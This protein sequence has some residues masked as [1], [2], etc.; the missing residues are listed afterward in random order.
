MTISFRSLLVVLASAWLLAMTTAVTATQGAAQPA[1]PAAKG[2][3]VPLGRFDKAIRADFFAGF[4][5]D[6][7]RFDRAMTLCETILAGDP[8]HAEA[9]VWHGGGLGFRAGAAFQS[10]DFKTGGELW[11]RGIAEMARAVSLQPDNVGVRIPRGA[12]LLEASRQMPPA[13]AL[14][15]VKIAMEDYEHVL[16]LQTPYF[17]KLSEHARGELLFGLAD[18]WARLGDKE[19]AR[20][21]FTRLT[22]SASGSGRATY[23]KAWLD[24]APPAN[25]G[26]CVGCH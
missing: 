13:Q 15:L 24:G 23:A 18:G 11:G 22:S 6:T 14:P 25:V 19:K 20:E 4:T 9:L 1:P 12:V 2:T 21:Y 10:G 7:A 17:N 16:K 3:V 8:D 26:R 5:G